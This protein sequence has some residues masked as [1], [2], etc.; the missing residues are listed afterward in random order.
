MFKYHVLWFL[1]IM[2]VFYYSQWRYDL[3]DTDIKMNKLK[4]ASK[5]TSGDDRSWTVDSRC[6]E[7]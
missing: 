3:I 5:G 1:L 4:V 6:L 2:G 7:P